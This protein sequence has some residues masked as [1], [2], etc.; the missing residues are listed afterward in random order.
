MQIKKAKLLRE[1]SNSKYIQTKT[2]RR[3]RSLKGEKKASF[4]VVNMMVLEGR[5]LEDL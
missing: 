2:A 5:P 4:L 1:A 3:P